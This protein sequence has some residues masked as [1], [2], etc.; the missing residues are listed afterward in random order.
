MAHGGDLVAELLI[1][2]GVTTFLGSRGARLPRF[3]TESRSVV[4]GSGT[5]WF[6]TSDRPPTPPTHLPG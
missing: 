6:A 4:P 3:T 2:Y 5:F 1:R